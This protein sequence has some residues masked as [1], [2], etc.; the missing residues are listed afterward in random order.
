MVAVREHL[1]RLLQ[2]DVVEGDLPDL[3]LQPAAPS[4]APPEQAAG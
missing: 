3:A 4:E 1:A 2:A